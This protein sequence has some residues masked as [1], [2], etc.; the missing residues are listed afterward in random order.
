MAASPE[1]AWEG[2]TGKNTQK[3]NYFLNTL[4][5]SYIIA[6]GRQFC[7]PQVSRFWFSWRRRAPRY[8]L[9]YFTTLPHYLLYYTTTLPHYL[10]YH[11]TYFTTLL[12][13]HTT[14]FTTL[15]TLPH[16]LLYHTTTLP[17]YFLYHTTTLPHYYF[18][19]PNICYL[20][21]LLNLT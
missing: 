18:T 2:P 19:R 3:Q 4:L 5:L 15:L 11:T 17:H 21:T 12:L 8:L 1:H 14:Y 10:L 16:Y 6:G 20:T 9:Y 7:A 13:Y